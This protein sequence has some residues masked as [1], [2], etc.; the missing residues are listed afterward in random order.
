MPLYVK[1]RSFVKASRCLTGHLRPQDGH[2]FTVTPNDRP[3]WSSSW[4]VFKLSNVHSLDA[5]VIRFK[6]V[7]ERSQKGWRS[8]VLFLEVL[9]LEEISF[10]DLSPAVPLNNELCQEHGTRVQ[11]LPFIFSSSWP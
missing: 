1:V 3:S 8:E 9:F 4:L 10:V 5:N 6:A 11:F 2:C 7:L